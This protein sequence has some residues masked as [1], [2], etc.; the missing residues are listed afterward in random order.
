MLYNPN[1]QSVALR[2]RFH[3]KGTFKLEIIGKDESFDDESYIF[4]WVAIYKVRVTD[5]RGKYHAFP[6][7]GE[8]G[9]GN[10]RVLQDYEIV[11][12]SHSHAVIYA[13]GKVVE[14]TLSIAKDEHRGLDICYR[15][16]D[17][18]KS[19]SMVPLETKGVREETD[20]YVISINPPA[21]EEAGLCIYMQQDDELINLVNH[22]VI[23]SEITEANLADDIESVR[24]GM[25]RD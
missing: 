14:V 4:D 22:L 5:C 13:E 17:V 24:V 16:T 2:V 19:L 10:N 18:N 20:Q 7:V 25:Y 6:R 12:L 11:P 15:L 1:N 8:A 23:N 9:W 3:R 21:G